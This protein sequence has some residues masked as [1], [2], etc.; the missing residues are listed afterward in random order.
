MLLE[1]ETEDSSAKLI[2]V[3]IVVLVAQCLLQDLH[4]IP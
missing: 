2:L 1:F 3:F 4:F